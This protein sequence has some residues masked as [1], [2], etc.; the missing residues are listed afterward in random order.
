[1]LSS[2]ANTPLTLL[3][4][5]RDTGF[6]DKSSLL[7]ILKVSDDLYGTEIDEDDEHISSLINQG[8][9]NNDGKLNIEGNIHT[10][11]HTPHP[12][13]PTHE[14]KKTNNNKTKKSGGMIQ[15]RTVNIHPLQVF[16]LS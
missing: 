14:S 12:D 9:L 8:D 7:S 16:S 11:M 5:S 6:I 1:M 15:I 13:P 2:A 3:F 10:C 4:W